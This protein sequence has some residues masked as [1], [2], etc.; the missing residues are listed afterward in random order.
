[1]FLWELIGSQILTNSREPLAQFLSVATVAASP[2]HLALSPDE[3]FPEMARPTPPHPVG[4]LVPT[5]PPPATYAR[6]HPA[7]LRVAPADPNPDR[8]PLS[9]Y[10]HTPSLL[11]PLVPLRPAFSPAVQLPR[12]RSFGVHVRSD[13]TYLQLGPLPTTG[14]CP[15]PR[16]RLA[17]QTPEYG[18][19]VR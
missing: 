19:Q 7:L 18:W 14:C 15:K 2:A 8:E 16:V 5:F 6:P 11:Q 12:P 10:S 17:I 9:G 13:Y 1:M 3:R 4:V